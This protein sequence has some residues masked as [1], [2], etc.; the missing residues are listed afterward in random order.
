MWTLSGCVAW[1]DG[2][3]SATLV[4][5]DRT[6]TLWLEPPQWGTEGHAGLYLCEGTEPS[7]WQRRVAFDEWLRVLEIEVDRTLADEPSRVL[8]T[9]L[10]DRIREKCL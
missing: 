3:L 5:V 6:V 8:F 4:D 10:I 2:S 7:M 9:E 1:R